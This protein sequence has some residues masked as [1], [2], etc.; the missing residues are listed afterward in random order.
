MPMCCQV[1]CSHKG[2]AAAAAMPGT[3]EA[4]SAVEDVKEGAG[5][6]DCDVMFCHATETT[7][8]SACTLSGQLC[9]PSTCSKAQMACGNVLLEAS[10][11]LLHL[12]DDHDLAR[13][14][15]VARCNLQR[16]PQWLT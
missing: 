15:H 8:S 3:S 6:S 5:M 11:A 9:A 16:S 1:S 10:R 2:A 13:A 14:Q 4:T 12:L 7:C